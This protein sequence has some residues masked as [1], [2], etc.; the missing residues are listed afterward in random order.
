MGC[1]QDRKL[2]YLRYYIGLD[3][4]NYAPTTCNLWWGSHPI[5]F[6][7]FSHIIHIIT[8]YINNI[9]TGPEQTV[10]IRLDWQ[11]QRRSDPSHLLNAPTSQ[12]VARPRVL[13]PTDLRPGD[14]M[15]AWRLV[16]VVQLQH[17]LTCY[18]LQAMYMY[19]GAEKD[20][21]RR[22]RLTYGETLSAHSW[23][24]IGGAASNMTVCWVKNTFWKTFRKSCFHEYFTINLRADTSIARFSHDE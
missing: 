24:W 4:L 1:G 23:S 22:R 21:R 3:I 20:G 16:W 10:A 14:D 13:V 11:V 17:T 2:N 7:P 8:T 5:Y 12:A 9:H 15:C 6:P 18:H 19:R